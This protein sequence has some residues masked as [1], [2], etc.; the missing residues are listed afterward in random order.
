MRTPTLLVGLAQMFAL[1][2]LLVALFTNHGIL[3]VLPGPAALSR[4]GDVLSGA[5]EVVQTGVPPVEP[6]TPILCLVVIAIGLVAVLVDSLAVA[7]ATPAAAGLVLLCVYAVPASLSD[8]MLPWWSFLLGAASYALLLAVDGTHRHQKWRDRP[9]IQR[10]RGSPARPVGLV[11][12][13]C[14][15]RCCSAPSSPSIGTVGQL[16]GDEGAR[17]GSGGL[18]IKPFTSLRGMLNQQGNVELFRRP[19][20]GRRRAYLRALTLSQLRSNGGWLAPARCPAACRT[21]SI[22]PTGPGDDGPAPSLVEI[23]P[24]N[25]E[26]NWAAGVR[27]PAADSQDCPPTSASTRPAAR[28]RASAAASSA[29]TASEADLSRAHGGT[30]CAP[31]VRTTARSTRSTAAAPT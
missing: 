10:A 31:P 29:S 11:A 28:L 5:V 19:R 21:T 20:P 2:C 13:R 30:S 9:A 1:M 3:G 7:A 17:H 12:V 16:P 15:S 25:S 27:R 18:G 24:M 14:C 22:L 6:T 8:D 26:D 4:L 23:E